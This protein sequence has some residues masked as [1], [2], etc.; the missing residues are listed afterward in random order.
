MKPF[1][2]QIEDDVL[3]DL[4]T[5]LK[6]TR[7]A[8][9][10]GNNLWSYG[11]EGEYLG[12]LLDYW[13]TVFDWRSQESKMNTFNHYLTKIDDIPIHFIYEKGKGP[14]PKPLI[15]SHGWP[16]T[17]WDYRKVIKPLTDPAAFGGDPEDA[18]DVIV[19]SLPGYGFSTPLTQT[20]I[21]FWRTADIWVELMCN[22]LGYNEF[23][24]QGGDWGSGVTLQLGH[25][26]ADKVKAIYVHTAL[27]LTLF[28][29]ALPG[30]D[31]YSEDEQRWYKKI[32][33]FAIHGS[34]YSALQCTC[35]QTIAYALNDSPIGLCAWILEKR[36][37]WG[38]CKGDVETR[39]SKDDILTT[40]MIYWL[41]ESYG[42][43]GRYYYEA[44]NNPWKP[45]HDR[46]PQVE[47]PTSI[48]VFE[49]DVVAMPRKW[50]ECVHNLK[51]WKI[52]ES[53][54]HFG[55]ME[56]PDVIIDEVRTFFRDYR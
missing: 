41:T 27:P 34:G 30:R 45:S 20:G 24:A 56:E 37:L 55:P 33:D 6:R 39:F 23:F 32:Q 31:E 53:G 35:P 5:R 2:V 52:F 1:K 15:M 9:D 26:Y 28:I 12:E 4:Q 17:F 51:R 21:N 42:T 14:N 48:T 8:P 22:V 43:S 29:K 46:I 7:L 25:K 10:F 18:F 11:V 44:R 13:H 36:R 40:V 47:S 38:D 3:D 54:G 16:W 19:P 49:N 50:A